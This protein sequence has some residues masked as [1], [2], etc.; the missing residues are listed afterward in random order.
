MIAN[1][2][3]KKSLEKI[4]SNVSHSPL[5]LHI[6]LYKLYEQVHSIYI[7]WENKK[8]LYVYTNEHMVYSKKERK[9]ISTQHVLFVY[10]LKC[11][12]L[13][14][15]HYYDKIQRQTQRCLFFV[16]EQ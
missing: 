7:V 9:P 6:I 8:Q 1:K 15:L 5:N 14:E 3:I 11:P 10:V 2:A 13:G 4:K 16:K 12:E